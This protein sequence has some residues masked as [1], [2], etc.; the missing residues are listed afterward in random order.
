MDIDLRLLKQVEADR[1]ISFAELVQIIEEA[2]VAAYHRH[3]GNHDPARS[4]GPEN[5]QGFYSGSGARRSGRTNRC[6]N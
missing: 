3:V 4:S 6:R 5:R 2:V 1:E